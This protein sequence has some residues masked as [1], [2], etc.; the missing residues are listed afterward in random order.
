MPP[1]SMKSNYTAYMIVY[2]Y[3]C[4]RVGLRDSSVYNICV[5]LVFGLLSQEHHTHSY[6]R[7]SV[8]SL[9]HFKS[10]Y[11]SPAHATLS[12]PCQ[13]PGGEG[14]GL[15]LTFEVYFPEKADLFARWLWLLA[16]GSGGR[17]LKNA[18]TETVQ[19]AAICPV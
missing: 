3:F 7:N 9:T 10:T 17:A 14:R 15:P 12:S 4:F 6:K 2:Y 19:R 13:R 18:G 16:C 8:H 5:A 1:N 11:I